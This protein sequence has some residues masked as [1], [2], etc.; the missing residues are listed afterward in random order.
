M[1]PAI[2]IPRIKLHVSLIRRASLLLRNLAV[3]A[4][5]YSTVLYGISLNLSL[6]LT[7][8]PQMS[9]EIC[10]I[11]HSSP[12]RIL[13]TASDSM[14]PFQSYRAKAG[15]GQELAFFDPMLKIDKERIDA[16]D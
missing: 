15:K 8:L 13:Q 2:R 6:L 16:V 5:I 1:W 11:E 3:Q 10:F 12:S 7:L 14:Q 9:K 4:Y